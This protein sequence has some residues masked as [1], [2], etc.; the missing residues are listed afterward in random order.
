M[1]GVTKESIYKRALAWIGD[2]TNVVKG[3]SSSDD[4]G[5]YLDVVYDQELVSLI[6]ENNWVCAKDIISFTKLDEDGKF[7]FTNVFFIPTNLININFELLK[8]NNTSF[9]SSGIVGSNKKYYGEQESIICKIVGRKLYT[10][11]E[12]MN[13]VECTVKIEPDQMTMQFSTCLCI[14]LAILL[15]LRFKP[16]LYSILERELSKAIYLANYNNEINN[17]VM[18]SIGNI[19]RYRP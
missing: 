14:R 7:G 16:S 12:T 5:K 1:V 18:P 10:I 15:C 2:K 9:N 4:I 6:M 3:T 19:L 8:N 13:D 17:E 11:F